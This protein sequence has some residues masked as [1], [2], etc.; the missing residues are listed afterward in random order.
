M[1]VCVAV[2]VGVLVAVGVF[3]DVDVLVGV[4]VGVGVGVSVCVLVGVAVG[5]GVIVEVGVLVGVGG[6]GF[7]PT[8]RESYTS[9][10]GEP[11]QFVDTH[12]TWS[13]P[14]P[15]PRLA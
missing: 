8:L 3:V 4:V 12:S 9:S 6:G 2:E 7:E 15:S 1:G 11:L 14:V 5:V 10:K 13:F